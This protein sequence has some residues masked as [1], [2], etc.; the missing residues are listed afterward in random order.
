MGAMLYFGYHY[1]LYLN[2]VITSQL[3]P[4]IVANLVLGFALSGVDNYGH[5]GGLIGG[6]FAGMIV[7]VEGKSDKVDTK[8]GIIVTIGLF[9]FLIYM[10]FFR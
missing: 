7:G 1:R 8:N 3:L 4:I 9:G 6:L 10:L 2:S 5:I